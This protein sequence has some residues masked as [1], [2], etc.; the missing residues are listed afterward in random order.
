M[1][2]SGPRELLGISWTAHAALALLFAGCAVFASA[3][4]LRL[5]AVEAV[6]GSPEGEA[7]LSA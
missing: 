6:C 3:L 7:R 1:R 5:S 2:W 4:R